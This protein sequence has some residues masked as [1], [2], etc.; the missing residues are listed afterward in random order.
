M[1]DL[2]FIGLIGGGL[3]VVGVNLMPPHLASQ[4]S[5]S[6]ALAE[7]DPGEKAT[8]DRVNQ[9]FQRLRTSASH[10]A[11]PPTDSLQIC[12]RL[13]LGLMGTV[14]SLQEIRE[15]EAIP[16]S[17]RVSWWLDHL[18]DDRRFADYYAE[19]LTR[20]FAG[21][22]NGPFLFF[23][24]RR[25]VAWLAENISQ[26]RPYDLIVR[27]LIADSGLWT[28]RPATNF[29]SVTSQPDNGNQPDP[30]RLAG[31]V[32]RAFLGLRLD[33]AQCHN[34]PFAAWVKGDFE[35]LS[36]FFGQTH[37]GF[38][39]IHDADGEYEVLDKKTQSN[40]LVAPK[41]PFS[42]ELVPEAG[43]RREQLAAWITHPKNPYFAQA[44]VNRTWAFMFGRPLVEPVDNLQ[45]D[46][47]T[48]EA[49]HIL[50]DDFSSHGFDLRR[51][52]RV[53]ASTEVFRMSSTGL[54][55]EVTDGPADWSAFPIT[56]LRPEQVAGS[57]LQA[58]SIPTINAEIHL[59]GRLIR[60]GEK[61]E[62]VTRYGDDGEDEF[63]NRGGTIPQRLLMM[64]GKMVRENV[65]GL[66]T[67]PRRVAWLAADD[68]RAVESIYLAALTRRPSAE[69][70]AY[71]DKQLKQAGDS[72]IDRIQD[73]FWALI[74]STEFSWNH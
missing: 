31:R 35:G 62:F 27:D 33:C 5:P 39:G 74:N 36:A 60:F 40:R 47:Q 19:R 38:K 72:R 6:I 9:S 56:R 66:N 28:D 53:I 11:A 51:L 15:L 34:H 59:L 7:S 22:E 41:V 21:T 25:F 68:P 57:V 63:D 48:P 64:N 17:V 65:A 13:S 8:V 24:R 18:F 49:L 43:S 42:P 55:P 12:R 73:L 50:A 52:I 69:E 45:T 1:R 26:N 14:P 2:F 58:S 61:N 67:S 10:Q 44:T 70:A 46:G 37:L 23:R 30:V 71:F 29:I 20:V 32:T 16:E 4:S 3:L 54:A